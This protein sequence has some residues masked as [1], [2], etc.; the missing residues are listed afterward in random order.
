MNGRQFRDN[1]TGE[2][3]RV[4]DSFENIAILE[5]K[6]KIDVRR[7]TD[8]NHF[9]EQIDPKSFFNINNTYNQ[10]ADKIKSIETNNLSE[11]K[12]TDLY[13]NNLDESKFYNTP[14]EPTTNESAIVQY[15]EEDERQELLKKYGIIDNTDA[16]AKQ[17]ESFSKLLND[18]TE[19]NNENVQRV[20]INRSE[21]GEVTG[22]VVV[23][24]QPQVA[25]ERQYSQQVEDPIQT[26]FKGIKRSV[27]FSLDLQLNNKIPKLEFIEMMEDSYEKSIIDYLASE[28]SNDLIK[29]PN[30]LKMKIAEKIK[31]MVYKKTPTKKVVRRNTNTSTKKTVRKTNT[32]KKMEDD[33]VKIIEDKPKRVTK[34][35]IEAH[36]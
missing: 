28:I 5:N 1:R 22:S 3:V 29:D 10:I 12:S 34:K 27:D 21:T 35:E 36:D 9:T 24:N 8:S 2:V 26:M 16:I 17:K 4:I 6:Q 18:D 20:E 13:N 19:V 7:L 14:Y 33:L 32:Q 23:N 11:E 31:E 15:S 25:H 30:S